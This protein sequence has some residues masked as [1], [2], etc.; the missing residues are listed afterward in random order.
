MISLICEWSE[1][2]RD[3]RE[4]SSYPVDL[5]ALV[6]AGIISSALRSRTGRVIIPAWQNRQPRETAAHDL[7]PARVRLTVF[8]FGTR[9][10]GDR[11][12][13]A[14]CTILLVDLLLSQDPAY[15]IE[16]LIDQTAWNCKILHRKTVRNIYPRDIIR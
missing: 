13:L 5:I 7:Q 12:W 2:L 1:V 11:A 9:N 6:K 14:F 16:T 4:I 8:M 10:L 15:V 3:S